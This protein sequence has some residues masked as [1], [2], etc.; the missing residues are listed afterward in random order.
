MTLKSGAQRRKQGSN[1]PRIAVLV[2]TSTNWGRRVVTGINNYSRKHGLWQL[3]VEARGLEEHIKVPP[4]WRGDG[5]IARVGSALMAKELR[6]HH[7]PVVN[8]SGIHLPGVDFLRVTTDTEKTAEL[9]VQ[10]F[11]NRG[12]RNFAYFSLLGLSYVAESQYAFV[13]KVR[14]AGCECAVQGVGVHKGAEP[15]W[16]LDILKLARWLK[17]LPKPVG[18]LTWNADSGRQIIYACERAGLHVPEEVALL[19][20]SD[21]DLLCEVSHI[22][23]SAILVAGEQIGY[24][25]AELLDRLLRG[26]TVPKEPVIIPPLGI[27]TRQSTETLAI[28]DRALGAAVSFIRM[29]A[30]KLIQVN[31]VA[32]HAGISRRVLERRFAQ[33]LHRTVAEEIR[34]VHLERA[35]ALLVET[36]M[37]IPEVAEASGFGSPEY[38]AYVFNKELGQTP[39]RY[40]KKIRGW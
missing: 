6:A 4:G 13:T 28:R 32:R 21:D 3:F 14:D 12:F 29:N 34:R 25:A 7:L 23:I 33:T 16:N 31:E 19:S 24:Q 37:P 2:D 17:D 9:A 39:L 26:R 40:R 10:H 22:P 1:L 36:D 30:A 27:V 38:L 11:L 35:K 5:I 20:G 8:V 18:I 15:D